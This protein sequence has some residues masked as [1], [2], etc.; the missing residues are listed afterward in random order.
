MDPIG[1]EDEGEGGDDVPDLP[2]DLFGDG[3]DGR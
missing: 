3:G 2:D 1:T